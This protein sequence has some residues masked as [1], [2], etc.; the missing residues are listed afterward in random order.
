MSN[1]E[2]IRISVVMATF[3]RRKSLEEALGALERQNLKHEAYEVIVVDDGST[4]DASD[5][6]RDWKSKANTSRHYLTQRNGG[7]AAARNAG[8]RIA[9]G[10]VVAFTDD[11]CLADPDWLKAIDHCMTQ[12]NW[13]AVQGATYTDKGDI[14][15][16]THQ[17]DN[18]GGNASVPTCNAAYRKEVLDRL[19]GFDEAFPFPHNEDA[20]LAWRAERFGPVGFDSTIRMYHPARQDSFRKVSKRMKIL[21]SEFRLYWKNPDAYEKKRA[22]SPWT[23]IY[24]NIG[25]KTQLYYLRSR[26]K[27]IGRPWLMLQGLALT[28]LWWIDLIVKFPAFYR[29][30]KLN[31]KLFSAVR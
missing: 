30:D 1:S 22:S 27:Y 19:D 13:A 14:T 28:F 4:D 18:E 20:D 6:L 17:I 21:E 24:W 9:R 29:A 23:N 7:P 15:P 10:A 31:K 25:C 2:V 11:D 12:N 16:L 8:V 26:L 5:F 3:N